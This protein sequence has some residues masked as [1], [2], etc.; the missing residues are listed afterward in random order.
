MSVRQIRVVP[1]AILREKAKRVLEI[2]DSVKEL[3]DDMLETMK[4][5]SGVG[6]AANQVGVAL[7]I[8]VIQMPEE[9]EI[10][11]VNPEIVKKVVSRYARKV[12]SAP[13]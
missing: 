8:V 7:R 13:S 10:V 4:A 5:A 2:D 3:I 12:V 6:L 11:L 1:D 9:E